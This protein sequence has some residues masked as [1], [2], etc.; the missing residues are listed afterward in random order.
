MHRI[1]VINGP[2]LNLL[3][4]REPE[5]YGDQTLDQ[6]N[7]M[8]NC[9]AEKL[10]LH[11]QFFQSN[12]EGLIIDQIQ[13]AKDQFDA[14]L[15]NP[16]ALTHYSYALHDALAAVGMPFVDVHLSNIFGREEFREKSVTASLAAGV[17]SGFGATGYLLGLLA[18]NDLLKREG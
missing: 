8:L 5:I 17:I 18:L 14:I 13:D 7:R 9:E 12:H 11:L 4:S 10:G 6:V 16:A 2:N 1:L 3:G 15:I